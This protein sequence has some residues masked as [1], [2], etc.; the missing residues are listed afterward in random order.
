MALTS[1][2]RLVNPDLGGDSSNP[3]TNSNLALWFSAFE[4]TCVFHTGI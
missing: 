2:P 4:R 3:T 1:E